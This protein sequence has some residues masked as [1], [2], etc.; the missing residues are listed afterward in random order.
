[1]RVAS[2]IKFYQRV[3]V[4][5]LQYG[6]SLRDT[7]GVLMTFIPS[8]GAIKLSTNIEHSFLSFYPL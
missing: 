8:G 7:E 5:Q 4:K 2:F 3:R 1:V 6:L